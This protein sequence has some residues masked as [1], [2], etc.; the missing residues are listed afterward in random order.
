MLSL[1]LLLLYMSFDL[2]FQYSEKYEISVNGGER[3]KD[4]HSG[5]H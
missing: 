4:K 3:V 2:Q 5:E 1:F